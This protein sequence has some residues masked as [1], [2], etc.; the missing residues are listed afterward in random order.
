MKPSHVRSAKTIG[1]QEIPV[2]LR[3]Y[4]YRFGLRVLRILPKLQESGC[5]RDFPEVPPDFCPLEM[6]QSQEFDDLWEDAGTEDVLE[7]IL[8]NKSLKIPKEWQKEFDGFN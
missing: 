4:P 5:R 6:Y 8:G 1:L 2:S 3:H 7:Y